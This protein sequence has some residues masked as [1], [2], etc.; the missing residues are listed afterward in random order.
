MPRQR[1]SLKNVCS[2]PLQNCIAANGKC[3]FCSSYHAAVIFTMFWYGLSTE[4]CQLDEGAIEFRARDSQQDQPEWFVTL[5]HRAVQTGRWSQ[6]EFKAHDS[7][8]DLPD[9]HDASKTQQ[10]TK[11]TQNPYG[12]RGWHIEKLRNYVKPVKEQHASVAKLVSGSIFFKAFLFIY[13][14]ICLS[15][16]LYL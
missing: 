9:A 15:I 8:E 14:S 5:V 3:L 6:I 2:P 1:S 10:Q 16:S 7:K 13:L 11:Q 4:R 12:D